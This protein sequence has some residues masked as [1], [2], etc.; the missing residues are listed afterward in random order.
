VLVRHG[1]SGE[2]QPNVWAK[3]DIT[4]EEE[5]LRRILGPGYR[6]LP[7]LTTAVAYQLLEL[8]CE[9]LVMA[10][11]VTRHGYNPVEGAA[12]IGE[13]DQQKNAIRDRLLRASQ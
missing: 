12:K 13:L 11:L 6:D 7:G 5:D 4:L 9:R 1:W 10:K 3:I 8:E 2:V